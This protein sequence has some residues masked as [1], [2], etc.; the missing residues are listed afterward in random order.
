MIP[1][2]KR[3]LIQ[4]LQMTTITS[5]N[6]KIIIFLFA[7]ICF[8]ATSAIQFNDN[9]VDYSLFDCIFSVDEDSPSSCVI[10]NNVPFLFCQAMS[11]F[12][13]PKEAFHQILFLWSNLLNR[14]PP[15]FL[16]V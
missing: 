13:Q 4:S 11:F 10:E 6:D 1:Q 2:N 15:V 8:I 7:F 14:A 16:P 12:L 9:V 5:H 3:N